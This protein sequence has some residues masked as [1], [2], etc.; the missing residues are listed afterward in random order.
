MGV[1]DHVIAKACRL[2][3]TPD[4]GFSLGME[5]ERR[6]VCLS[7]DVIKEWDG[8]GIMERRDDEAGLE[9]SQIVKDCDWVV[10]Q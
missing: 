6:R 3:Q 1:A 8:R 2:R 7:Q 4:L 9:A 10:R 5:D